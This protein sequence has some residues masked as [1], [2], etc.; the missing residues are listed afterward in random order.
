MYRRSALQYY[1]TAIHVL[2]VC[3]FLCVLCLNLV[4]W[5]VARCTRAAV[6]W[7][8]ILRDSG[9]S[10]LAGVLLGVYVPMLLDWLYI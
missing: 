2:C 9:L 6:D 4:S 8:Y 5:G 3:V 10:W 1:I 7:L